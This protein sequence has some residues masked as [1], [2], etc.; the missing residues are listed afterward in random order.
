MAT[1]TWTLKRSEDQWFKTAAAQAQRANAMGWGQL[2]YERSMADQQGAWDHADL[3]KAFSRQREQFASPWNRKNMM[4]SGMYQNA[5]GRMIGDHSENVARMNIGDQYRNQG[6]SLAG[7]Q[8]DQV[9][10]HTLDDLR[11]QRRAYEETLASMI[12]TYG[13]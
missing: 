12:R 4:N 5:L 11:D 1:N 3:S 2:N 6:F 8:L 7:T 13:A 10:Q 9:Q